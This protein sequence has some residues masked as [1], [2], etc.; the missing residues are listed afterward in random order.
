MPQ[1]DVYR[2]AN[3]ETNARIPFLVDVQADL[4][5]ELK[6]RVVIPLAKA[7]ELTDFPMTYL[8]PMVTFDGSGYLLLTQQLAG[9][10]QAELGPH[11]G[12]L[13][14]QQ[15]AITGAIEFLIRGF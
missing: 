2:N 3:S 4:F 5:E 7:P 10:S 9:I 14:N 13:A 8:A 11:A 15:R 1:F 12:T 6:T